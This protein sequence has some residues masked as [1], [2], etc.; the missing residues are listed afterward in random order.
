METSISLPLAFLAGLLSF[1][2]PCLL[3]LVP[4]YL[5]YLAGAGVSAGQS[6]QRGAVFRHALVF[7]LAFSATFII[8]F[9]LPTT[10]LSN[11]LVR[12]DVWIG[13]VAGAILILFGLH[14]L[15]LLRIPGLD[16]TFQW[17]ASSKTHATGWARSALVGVAFATGWTPC[18]GPLLG[19]VLTLAFTDPSRAI[20][21]IF[22][23]AAGLAIPFLLAALLLDRAGAW[24][25]WMRR[26]AQLIEVLSAILVIGLGVLLLTDR[27]TWL[28]RFFINLTPEWLVEFL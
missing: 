16:R 14:I 17:D 19:A 2:S 20:I 12:Y 7:V 6:F 13:R 22:A 18:V 1:L 15:H 24:M 5:G 4:A 3:P 26:H 28:N 9:G 25:A 10:L 8:L 27:L 21:F 11:F 23:Y